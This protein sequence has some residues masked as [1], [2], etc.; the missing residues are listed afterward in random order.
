MRHDL[1][2][3]LIKKRKENIAKYIYFSNENDVE[4]L[5]RL[6]SE[7]WNK[8]IPS[9]K[10][11]FYAA[12]DGSLYTKNYLGFSIIA[13]SGYAESFNPQNNEIDISF[14]GDIYPVV[15]SKIDQIK[16]LATL[17][18]FLCETKALLNLAEKVKPQLI[19]IDGTITS[20][21][22]IPYPLTSWFSNYNDEEIE[23][24][25][26]ELIKE[27]LENINS[28]EILSLKEEYI[29]KI[30]SKLKEDKK[31]L[32]DAIVFQSLYYEF[33]ITLYKLFTLDYNPNIIGIA[34]TSTGKDLLKQSLPDI[35]I[36]LNLA[37]ELGYSEIVEQKVENLK[38]SFGKFADISDQ[39]NNFIY[40]LD[41]FSFYAKYR[42]KD[43]INLIEFYQNPN[44]K[45]VDVKE[46]LDYLNDISFGGLDYPFKLKKVDNEVRITKFDFEFIE[47]ELGLTYESTGREGL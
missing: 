21:F 13:F 35:R 10:I 38:S 29:E 9:K 1:L 47:R 23:N 31:D 44:I 37:D 26:V 20:R 30:R 15:M 25:S 3:E 46:I 22:V 16:T 17:S 28:N 27:N 18:M 41:I 14:L 24:I 33:L 43:R 12:A 6:V 4:E 42:S 19:I 34:K 8:Y 40:G 39:I 32:L 2:I 7:K 36:F 11:V 45:T 5:K